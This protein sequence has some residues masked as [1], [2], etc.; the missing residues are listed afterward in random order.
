MPGRRFATSTVDVER[1][2]LT[3]AAGTLQKIA[4]YAA[5]SGLT[6]LEAAIKETS[7][8]KMDLSLIGDVASRMVIV[9]IDADLIPAGSKIKIGDRIKDT[10][11]D[12]TYTVMDVLLVD[13]RVWQ[14]RAHYKAA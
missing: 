1:A 9:N 13:D 6:G 14:C 4:A 2:T 12:R 3:N 7:V 10:A 5:V 8:T 11:L